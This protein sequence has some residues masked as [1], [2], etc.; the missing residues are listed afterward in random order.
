LVIKSNYANLP[1]I[2]RS[3]IAINVEKTIV[4]LQKLYDKRAALDKQI[5]A[6]EKSFASA[7]PTV[8]S[9]KKTATKKAASVKKAVAKKVAPKM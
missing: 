1:A 2:R 5:L 9:V 4:A 7:A 8:G 3:I 6:A